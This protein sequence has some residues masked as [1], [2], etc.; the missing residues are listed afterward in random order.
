MDGLKVNGKKIAGSNHAITDTGSSE[1]FIPHSAANQ[2]ARAVGATAT[3]GAFV[4][5]CSARFT[6]TL[7]VNGKNFD[8][9]NDQLVIPVPRTNRCRLAVAGQNENMWYEF[10]ER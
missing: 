10:D 9:T 3:G 6:V 1:I 2:I 8:I 7:I 5:K 4:I